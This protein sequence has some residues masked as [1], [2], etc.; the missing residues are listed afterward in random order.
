MTASSAPSTDDAPLPG[1]TRLFVLLFGSSLTVMA[2]PIISPI[3]P[4]L[5][6]E[7]ASTPD[8]ATLARLSLT[9]PSLVVAI[10]SPFVGWLAD[11]IDRRRLLAFSALLYAMAGGFGLVAWSMESLIFSRALLGLGKAILLTIC[12]LL[13]ADCYSGTRLHRVLGWQ[14]AAIKA[15]GVTF[16]LGAGFLASLHWRAPFLL[17]CLSLL[18]LPGAFRSFPG[19]NTGTESKRPG[20]WRSAIAS[21]ALWFAIGLALAN[22]AVF[23]LLPTELPFLLKSELGS[24]EIAVGSALALVAATGAF[25]STAFS[26]LRARLTFPALFALIFAIMGLGFTAVS[27]APSLPWLYGAMVIIG[28]S[29]GLVIPALNALVI[30]NVKAD[31]LGFSVGLL[32]GS[33]FFGQFVSPILFGSLFDWMGARPAFM[34]LGLTQLVLSVPVLAWWFGNRPKFKSVEL[35]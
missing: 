5:E 8:I 14:S 23:Y 20:E 19:A 30:A 9:I 33:I 24:G 12:T 25:S 28:V 26:W 2:G 17:F 32:G 31:A 35:R 15:G 11:R 1:W 34:T 10:A 29:L 18:I 21:A 16:V 22:Q 7:F 4:R 27:S 13:I 6:Q 3:L